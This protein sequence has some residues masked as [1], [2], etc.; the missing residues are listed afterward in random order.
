MKSI[1]PE[2]LIMPTVFISFLSMPLMRIRMRCGAAGICR[3]YS[4]LCQCQDLAMEEKV[5]NIDMS[6]AIPAQI[7]FIQGKHILW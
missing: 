2:I 3:I 4:T 5:H 1:I 7:N 6:N